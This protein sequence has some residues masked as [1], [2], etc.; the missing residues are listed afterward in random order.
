[1]LLDVEVGS[2]AL[3]VTVPTNRPDLTR[4]ADLVEEI[5]RL[6]DFDTFAATVPTGPA[7]GLLVEQSRERLLRNLL[8]GMGLVQ[9]ISLPFV[10]EEELAA[11][12]ELDAKANGVVTVRNPLREDQSKL[13]Q[14]LL[15]VLLRRLRE[16]RN[17]GAET[18][19]LFETG[20]VFFARPWADDDR[21][22]DQPMR[23][24]IAIIGPFGPADHAGESRQA[25]ANTAL[26]VMDSLGRGLGVSITR[27]QAAA[28]A[29]YHPTRSATLAVGGSPIGY[30]GELHPDL[31]DAF[32][33][34]AR[35]AIAEVHMEALVAALP[36]VQMAAV[37]T[38]PHV[39]FDLS[40]EVAMHAAAGDLLM[41][42]Q[43]VSDLVE[44]A[45]VFDDYRNPERNLRAIAIKYRLRAADRTLQAD[46]IAAIRQRM[47]DEAAATGAKLRGGG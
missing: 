21:V 45:G 20:R 3:T 31:A 22:P 35:V 13:R 28:V 17:R 39:D 44:S 27:A 6:A 9:A 12:A 41:L 36:R 4:P 46:E 33:L 10:S 24:G 47:I 15:P 25:D 38:F 16:N 34:G 37:S 29:G 18:V 30:A 32:D 5:A 19:A 2:D 11:F 14:S 40:F 7:G 8:R 23:L 26:A 43:G 42:T 1:L